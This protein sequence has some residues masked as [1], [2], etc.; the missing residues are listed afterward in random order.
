MIR[1]FAASCLA[2]V[3]LTAYAE[4]P[5]DYAYRLPLTTA[6]DAAFFRVELPAQVYQGVV[7]PDLGDVRVFNAE[8]APVAFAF[9]PRPAAAREAAASVALPLFPLRVEIGRRDLGDIAITLKRDAAGTT[10]DL[11]TR[12]GKGVPSERLAGYLID[13]S[14]LK[15]PLSALTLP[16]PAG[17]NMTTQVRVE[18]SD[19]LAAWRNV[20]AAPLVELEFGGRR[21][22]RDRIEL[23]STSAKYL[24]LMFEARAPTPELTSVRG[25]FADRAVEAPRQWREVAGVA[26]TERANAYTFDL[27]GTFPVD[28][29]TLALTEQ[30][31]VAPAQ[32]FVRAATKDQWR[33]IASPVFYRLRQEGGEATN[34]PVSILG[35]GYRYWQIVVDPKAGAIGAKAP[36]LSAGYYPGTI[37][38]AARGEGPFE[39]AYGSA[40]AVPAALPIE[41]LVPG[42]DRAKSPSPTFSL[43]GTGAPN[44]APA[45]HALE[46]PIDSKRWM[47]WGSLALAS[48]VLGWMALSLSRQMRRAPPAS[49]D[50]GGDAPPKST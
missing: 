18:A 12:D 6:G 32:V 29:L 3:A 38:F 2:A 50:G 16:L 10:V 31:T 34:P 21:L 4:A 33:L 17:A 28:R 7:R 13:A 27:G 24:R 11:A 36:Q 8:G 37:V 20:V 15:R 39:L 30:N 5:G 45:G 44:A 26:D 40:R 42:Y 47:L 41:T 19:D 46:T 9:M 25:E 48:L 23:P 43:A 35:G 22:T 1:T 14:D 49:T